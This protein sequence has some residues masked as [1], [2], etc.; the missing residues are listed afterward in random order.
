[1][2][3]AELKLLVAWITIVVMGVMLYLIHPKRSWIKNLQ[4]KLA[5]RK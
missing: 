1:M 2:S 3:P 5:A 4:K